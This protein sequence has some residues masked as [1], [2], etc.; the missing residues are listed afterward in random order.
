MNNSYLRILVVLIAFIS[1]FINSIQSQCYTPPAYCT[2]ISATNVGSYGMGIQNVTLNTAAIPAQINNTTS[3]G[4]GSPIYFDYTSQILTAA[5]GAVV[6]YSIRGGN[7]NQTKIRL[8]IDFDNNGTFNTTPIAT[9][10]GELVLDLAN[11][12]VANTTV[13]GTFTLPTLSAGSYRIRVASDGQGNIPPPCGPSFYS[14]DYEDYTLMVASG[15]ADA[16][17]TGIL[18]PTVLN[19]SPA[20][21]PVS[22]TVRNLTNATM[23]SISA[24]YTVNGGTATTQTFTGL[25]IA[26][27]ASYT[28]TFSTGFTAPTLGNYALK[29]F[30]YNVNGT[31]TQNTPLNDTICQTIPLLCTGPLT[32][33]Y[34]ID[35][36]GG[37]T[38]TNFTSFTNAVSAL[39]ACGVSGPTNFSVAAGT[40]TDTL[41]IPNITGVSATNT[42]TFDGGN[43][44]KAT[45]ILTFPTTSAANDV[46]RFNMSRFVTV[47]NMTLRS[48]GAT[49]GWVVHFMHDSADRVNNCNIE[50]TGAATSSSSSSFIAV[51]LNNSLT[52]YNTQSN[53]CRRNI[54][55]SNSINWGWIGISSCASLNTATN[56]FL[57]NTI[58]NSYQ[59][60]VYVEGNQVVKCNY[61]N[62]VPRSTTAGTSGIYFINSNVASTHF[63]EVLGNKIDNAGQY[64][65]YATSSAGQAAASNICANNMITGFR[66]TS[67]YGGI[68]LN[69]SSRWKLYHNSINCNLI[70]TSGTTAG[71]Y[72]ANS[73]F[74]DCRNNNIGISAT[75]GT[76]MFPVWANTTGLFTFLDYNNY[77]NASSPNLLQIN[78]VNLTA[79]NY[80]TA[81]PANG[82]AN[83]YNDNPAFVSST[84]L[85]TTQPCFNGATGLGITTDYDG[86]TR[87]GT[88][89]MGADELTAVPNNDIQVMS[90][91]TP[92][93]PLVA[94]SQPVTVVIRNLGN[95]VVSSFDVNYRLNNGTVVSEPY[96]GAPI[97]PCATVVFNFATTVTIGS[98][99]S[100][101]KAYTTSPNG[102]S[103]A[104]PSNDT[105]Q[106]T[107]C[108][109]M[110]GTYTINPL[111]SGS[112]NFT[113]FTTAIAALNCGGVNGAVTFNV[114]NGTYAE[115]LFLAPIMGTSATNTIKFQSLSG[116]AA[117]C[118]ISF[119]TPSS[120]AI[121]DLNGADFI[122]FD[123]FTIRNT[124]TSTGFGVWIR[125]G[126]DFNT[127]SNC[128]IDMAASGVNGY[129]VYQTNTIDNR[130][131]INGNTINGAGYGV[132]LNANSSSYS[133]R[134][135]ISNNSINGSYYYGMY[136]Q[137]QD[138][139]II[140]GNT[141]TSSSANS[142]YYGIYAYWLQK[143]PIVVKNKIVYTSSSA[144]TGN[145]YG[146]NLLYFNVNTSNPTRGLVANNMI[147]VG[148][149]LSTAYGIFMQNSCNYSDIIHNSVNMTNTAANGSYALY[150]ASGLSYDTVRN[151]IFHN[152][153]N[154]TSMGYAAFIY[155]G[156]Q[157]FYN[158][159]DFYTRN[160]NFALYNGTSYATY[161]AWKA[162]AAGGIS[163]FEAAGV[164]RE[165]TFTSSTDLHTTLPCIA[166]LGYNYSATSPSLTKVLDDYDGQARS[167]T[168]DLGCDEFT[169]APFDVATQLMTSPT[170][171]VFAL[172]TPYTIRTV[173]RNNGSTT[174]TALDMN[175]SVNGGA[176]TSQSFTGLSLLPCDTITL[177]F[178]SPLTLTASG[179]NA[180]K[181][182]N[183]LINTSNADGNN[184]ND[185]LVVNLCTS[186]N[187]TYSINKNLPFS[188]S[189]FTSV[190]QAVN[191]LYSCGMSGPV[192]LRID[193]G[194]GPYNEQVTFNGMIPGLNRT[195][196]LRIS[197]NTTRETITFNP[198]VATLQHTIRLIT[199]KHITLDSLT[200]NNTGAS[201]G[202]GVHLVTTA[203]SNFVT[204]SNINISLAS[205][206]LS[207]SAGIAISTNTASVTTAGNNGN[208]NVFDNNTITGGYYGI[209]A[210]GTSTTVFCK[211]NDV[212]NNRLFG[213]AFYGIYWYNQDSTKINGNTI[214][215]MLS[216]N[217]NS[218]G[219]DLRYTE[220]FELKKNK[221][222]RTG[223]YGIFLSNTNFQ[224]GTGTVR[225]EISNNMIGG[226]FYNLN[227]IGLYTQTQFRNIDF[228]HNTIHVVNQGNGNAFNMNQT[229][230][231]SHTG[232][233]FRNNTF[234]ATNNSAPV[235]YFY[236]NS[237]SIPFSNFLNNNI[238]GSNSSASQALFSCSN[239][240]TNGWILANV[241][242][243]ISGLNTLSCRNLDPQ[244]INGLTDL[245]SIQSPLSNWGTN[246]GAVTS[247]IDGDTRPL[248]PSSTVDVGA[249]EYNIP[250]LN[251]GAAS[252]VTPVAPMTTGTQDVIIQI[253]NYGL[254][255]VTSANVSY[256]VGVNGSV[257]TVA[258]TGSVAT[259]ASANV[260]FTGA[261]QYNFTGS[262]DTLIAWTDAPNGGVDGFIFNDTFVNNVVCQ[263]LAGTYTLDPGLPASTNNFVN[264]S[265]LASRLN[266]CGITGPV[267]INVAAG[268]YTEQFELKQYPGVSAVNTVTIK[269]ASGIASSVNL[270]FNTATLAANNYVVYMNGADYT[271]FQN[272]TM[273]NSNTGIG[274]YIIWQLNNSRFNT[275]QNV[276]FNGANTTSTSTNYSIIYANNTN[277]A[278]LNQGDDNNIINQCTFNNGSY[279]IYYNGSYSPYYTYNTTITNNTFS[280]QSAYATYLNFHINFNFSGNT[281]TTSTAN[282]FYGLYVSNGGVQAN[283]ASQFTTISKNNINIANNGTGMY[284]NYVN[285]TNTSPIIYP[286][287]SNNFIKIGSGTGSAYALF[288]SY[289]HARYYHNT[290]NV[291]SGS[292][293]TPAVYLQYGCCHSPL[294]E[295]KF[296]IVANSGNGTNAGQC[297]F[298]DMNTASQVKIDSNVYFQGTGA[299]SFGN[300]NGALQATFANW[301]TAMGVTFD[302]A[303]LVTNPNFVSSTNLRIN[304]GTNLRPV[305]VSPFVTDDIDNLNRCGI[306]D[307]GADHHPDGLDA[308]VS[309]ITSPANGVASPGLQDVKVL[310]TN[311]GSTT[312]TS[313]NVSYNI[314]GTVQ[315]KAWTGSLATCA[316]DTIVFTGAQ[317]YNFTG[318][319]TM[320]AFSNAPNGGADP[321]ATND[322]AYSSGCVGMGG[323]YTIGGTAGPTNFT[324]FG[325]AITAMQ[326]CGI[327]SPITFQVASGT[328][329]EQLSIPVIT[330]ASTT[331]TITFDGGNGNAATRILSFA[332]GAS[333]SGLSHVLRFNNCSFV[334]FR[335][336]TIS[337]SGTSNAWTVH[338]M[339]G[340][341]N[342]LINCIVDMTGNGTTSGSTN[343][344]SI[345]I[346]GSTTS[347]TTA[348][349]I[350]SNHRVDSCTINFGYYGIYSSINNGALTNFFTNN[351]FVNTH[352]SG[353]WFDNPQTVKFNNN[354]INTR[355][356]ST[357]A[358]PIY[359]SSA[360]P[361][362]SN[363]HEVNGNTILRTGQYG[364]FFTST[365]GGISAQ[366]QCYNNFINGM[367][368]TSSTT[369]IY[370]SS[371]SNW[372]LYHNTV[373]HDINSTSG[374]NYGI[375]IQ[376]GSNNA[377]RNNIL[378]T[379]IPTAFNWTPLFISP[380]SAASAVNSNNYWNPSSSNLVNIGGVNY[381]A[382]NF[383][384]AYPSGGGLN[385]INRNPAYVSSSNIRVTDA[386][387]NGENLGVSVDIDGQTR[388]GVPDMGADE[389]TT[390]PNNDIQVMSITVPAFPLA[391]G[392]QPVTVVIRN[393]GNN[394]V[395]SFD[396]NYRLNNGTVVTQAYSG[397]P[398]NPCAS[399]SFTFSTNVTIINGSNDL[400][401][402]TTAP[403]GVADVNPA[404]DTARY[405]SCLAMSGTYTINAS[406]SGSANFTTFTAAVNNLICGGVSGPVTFNVSNGTYNEQ[407]Q[408]PPILGASA[409]NTIR[410]Q[411]ATSNAAACILTFTPSASGSFTLYLNGAD[412]I[413]FDR[414]TI[415]NGYTASTVYTTWIGG[416]ANFNTFSNCIINNPV[417][418][419]AFAVYQNGSTDNFNTWMND[420]IN[421]GGYG[422]YLQSNTST[423][424]NRNT[425]S[426][427]FLNNQTS[428]GTANGIYVYYHDST[429][430][431]GNSITTNQS[432]GAYFGI[433]TQSLSR[434]PIV[435]KNRIYG[436]NLAGAS[437]AY[438]MQ[439]NGFANSGIG[440]G[441]IAN[442]FISMGGT[443]ATNIGLQMQNNSNNTDVMHNSI[444]MTSTVLSAN[445]VPFFYSTSL[446]G[447][448]V[449]NNIFQ[450][451]GDG[452]TSCAVANI[453]TSGTSSTVFNNNNYFSRNVTTFGYCG[454]SNGTA[455]AS[456]TAFRTGGAAI[457]SF[458]TSGLNREVL[459]VSNSDLHT[460]TACI[461]NA[462]FNVLTIVPDD[463]DGDTRTTTPDIGADQFVAIAFDN[464][465]QAIVSPNLGSYALATP[466]TVSVRV[467]NNGSTT[468]TALAM[469]YSLNGGAATSQSFTGLNLLPCDM[470]TLTFTATLTLT[471]SGSNVLRVFNGLINTSN[472]DGNN[473]NDTVSLNLCTPYS[474]TLTINKNL[475]LSSSNF[476][477]VSQAVNSLYSCGMSGP[478]VLRIDAG[479]GPY[480]EQV[481]FNGMITGLTR[482]NN[483]RIS[484]NTTRET[485]TFNPTVSNLQHT[486]R[487]I[488]VKHITLDSLT[489]NNTGANFGV[490]VHLV[491][492]AD[493]NFVTNSNINISLASTS[494][495]NSAGIAIS[496]NTSSPT[497]TGNSG[498]G[499]K[500]MN[501]TIT[502]GYYGI[503]TVGTNTTTFCRNNDIINNTITGQAYYGVYSQF[504]DSTKINQNT[505]RNLLVTNTIGIGI[506]CQYIERFEIN[507]N[508][509]NYVGQSGFDLSFMNFQNGT[510]TDRSSIVN[511]MIGGF[512]YNNSATGINLQ[513]RAR[514]IDINHN[515][516]S[517]G[518]NT[519]GGAF[520][521][522]YSSSGTYGGLVF[523][524]NSLVSYN[525][526]SSVGNFYWNN[527][528]LTPAVPFTAFEN[529]NIFNA[530]PSATGSTTISSFGQNGF[531]GTSWIG[532]SINGLNTSSSISVNPFYLN[533]L[534][535]LHTLNTA[536]SNKGT[537]VANVNIDI[538]GQARPLSP[539]VIVDIGADEYNVPADN[540]GVT[541]VISPSAPL[542]PGLQ[543][544]VVQIR[545]YGSTTLT[546]A[547]VRYKVG[548]NGTTRSIAWTGSVATNATTN[549]TFT[550]ANQHNFTGSFDTIIAWTDAPNG[551]PDG[552]TAND[553]AVSIICSPLSGTYT[554]DTTLVSG[555]GNFNSWASALAS[556]MNCGVS[557]P[558]TINVTQPGT[559]AGAIDIM[560]I[561]GSSS[562][563]TV[564]FNGV[565][566]VN[567]ILVATT[568]S[569]APAVLRF[570]N[571]N[572]VT[573]RNFT[574]RTLGANDGWCAHFFNGL[575]NRVT[576]C[577]LDI[578][579]A[580]TASASSNLIPVV[581]N[582]NYTNSGTASTT[583]NNHSV[584]SS[585]LNAGYYS[586]YTSN[587][588][589]TNTYRFLNNTMNNAYQ[590]GAYFN[591]SHAIK[592]NNNIVNMRGI[593]GGTYGLYIINNNPS[594]PNFHEINGNK[595]TNIGQYG[596]YFATSSNSGSTMGQVFNNM[597]SGFKSTSTNVGIYNSSSSRWNIWHNSINLDFASTSGTN[598]CIYLQNGGTIDLR[599]NILSVTSPTIVNATPL[600]ISPSSAASALN[601][602]LYYN[603]SSANLIGGAINSTTSN[604]KL[605]FPSG[606]GLGSVNADPRFVNNA[607]DL[608]TLNGCYT[609]ANLGVTVDIDNQTRGTAP[610]IGAD[611]TGPVVNND[612]GIVS[613]N[614]PAFPLVAG[615]TNVNVTLRNFGANTVSSVTVSYRVNGGTLTSQTL[616][617]LSL[618]PCDTLNFT[619]S[620]PFV[621]TGS[622][623]LSVFTSN[624][625]GVTDVYLNND[626][627]NLSLCVAMSGS[628]SI[629][630][631]GDFT[632]FTQAVS[633]LNCAGVNG[634]VIFNVLSNTFAEQ[635][636]IGVIQGASASNTITFDGGV[637]NAA[638]R[639]LT[640]A[641]SAANP[642]TFRLNGSQFV[643]IINLTI[644]S[645]DGVNGW[646]VSI[647][648]AKNCIVS[649][650]NIEVAGAGA[651]ATGSNLA[652]VVLN[653]STTSM[654]TGSSAI[655]NVYIDSNRIRGGFHG[656]YVNGNL[657]NTNYAYTRD[658]IIDSAYQNGIF[659]NNM[660]HKCNN[661][662]II[663]RV[664]GGP[665]NSAGIS[666]PSNYTQTPD[667]STYNYNQI[668]NAR[669]YGIFIS[670][671]FY[672]N[673]GIN[674]QVNNNVIGQFL[675]TGVTYGIFSGFST[676]NEYYH[677]TININ[678]AATGAS[679]AMQ[680]N[681]SSSIF[682]RNNIFAITNA[683][684]ASTS[685]PIQFTNSGS[686]T[687]SNNCYY[688]A[689]STNIIQTTSG[690]FTT[691]AITTAFPSG[692]GAGSITTDPQFPAAG[693]LRLGAAV[694]GAT[695]N[696]TVSIAS[697]PYDMDNNPRNPPLG[698]TTPDMGAYDKTTSNVGVS[699]VIS[700]TAV[701]AGNTHSI[702][703]RIRNYGTDAV[704]N[705]PVNYSLNGGTAVTETYVP[706]L[707][708]NDS[709]S[710][711]FATTATFAGCNSIR[712]YTSL[713]GESFPANDTASRNI[714]ANI[715]GVYTIN[716][717]GAGA[718][719]FT[720]FANAIAFLNCGMVTGPVTFQ[721]AAATYNEQVVIPSTIVG[722]TATNTITFDGG[723]GNAATRILTFAT[724]AS[725]SGLS[726]VLRF[727][728]CSFITFRNMTIRSSGI[729][730]AWTVH[731]MNGTNNRLNS[732]I[733]DMT[734][735]GTTST[736]TNFTSVV[737]N[738][739]T[740]SR[741]TNSTAANNHR[742]DSC[743]IN[744]GY[745]GIFTA[746]NNGALTNFF[747]NN[748]FANTYFSGG[749]FQ[750]AQTV[751]FNNNTINTRSTMTT[752]QPIYFTSANPSGLNFHEVNGNTIVRT[753]QYGIFF[754]S[755]QGGPSTQGQ[756]YNNFI[757]GMTSTS[758]TTG[759]Y[760]SSASNWNLYH[761]TVNHDINSTTGSSFGIQILNGSNNDVRNNILSTTI[762]TTVSWTPFLINPSSAVSAVNSNNYWNPSSS[763][764]VTIGGVN[765]TAA[766]FN[767][768]YP[769]GGGLNSINKNPFYVSASN[770]HVTS[771]CNNGENLGVLVDIDG[772]TRAGIP[773]MGA[774]EVTTVFTVS[775]T[776]TPVF[777]TTGG[778]VDTIVVTSGDTVV[779]SGTGANSYSWSGPQLITNAVSFVATSAGEYT[780]TGTTSGCTNTKKVYVKL[781][782]ALVTATTAQN[783]VKL[784]RRGVI[785]S[786][787]YY[788]DGVNYYFAIDTS[789]ITSGSLTGD[790]VIISVQTTIDSSKS[791]NGRNQEHAMYLMPRFWN[792][793]GSFTGTVKVRFPY[794]PSDTA[795]LVSLRDSA[796][797]RL[798]N[799][800]NIN[801]RAVKTPY[802]EWFKTVGRPYNASYISGM[803]GNKFPSTKAKPTV[804]YGVT[805]GGVH[806][807]ELGGITSFS[808]GSAGVGFGPGGGGGGVSLPATWAG[809]DVQTLESGNELT[810]KTA[811]EKNTDY[812][813]V[814]YSYDA[815]DFQVASHKIQAAGN[816]ASLSYYNFNHSDFNSF[817]Y[818]R[819]KQVDLDGQFDYS[820]IKL[821][822]RAKGKEFQV[823]VYPT[824]ILENGRITIEA[825]NI[826]KSQISLSIM[827]VSGKVIYTNSY[828]PSND[829]L[830]E[831]IE[832]YLLSSGV[833]F[834]EIS[835]GQGRDVVKVLR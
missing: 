360:N 25:S 376:N 37:F 562:V 282:N 219:M 371:A 386:C 608:H 63:H 325:A 134:N 661:N 748:N 423:Y 124:F 496:S 766:N 493:S 415:T 145:F 332:T 822:K 598:N 220:R 654:G 328:Y 782:S 216:S 171:S 329:T 94:G 713:A 818:Y 427:C 92:V 487:L 317:Q 55:D 306:T 736:S 90:I 356:S 777:S 745:Y 310:L 234:T 626:T 806:Y 41:Y 24:G 403:N 694:A 96:A 602:N 631:S 35:P 763:N 81:S 704:S 319:F 373:N 465:S 11:M 97:S 671:S 545:N 169:T 75:S 281:I 42:I 829:S 295:F 121:I 18:Q 514:N 663:M 490:G 140:S 269:S 29:Y 572:F 600:F 336:M 609:G 714:G 408:I 773:D 9:A 639:I 132:F 794:L 577:I 814:E 302:A 616:T 324:T 437:T 161:A 247:D 277:A 796:W 722:V 459:F 354:A 291:T 664:L 776:S 569:A 759:I 208:N 84:N 811:S 813:E 278:Q 285:G 393:L 381:T 377:V 46:V 657:V 307:V 717:S 795:L 718:T 50:F 579:G 723:S 604:Y 233:D 466:Y 227:P 476:T 424:S 676:N 387:N 734:G 513:S 1:G 802:L 272:M 159:N 726:H 184:I 127:I 363:F 370:L 435:T 357:T 554:I 214:D 405:T 40:Y 384:V 411:S 12:T 273:T 192:V 560:G 760:L 761:N 751:K 128:I 691:A 257:K 474:G 571:C 241:S 656:I 151:N 606:G 7:S 823:S 641:A 460:S 304:S 441:L 260:T 568:S 497:G 152:I 266:N 289:S 56:Y 323:V 314:N 754:T 454:S 489:I 746:I 517:M 592:F 472:A 481:T 188:S 396:V 57:S 551:Q 610:D 225:S 561:N 237:G 528:G 556:L 697:L 783:G 102:S 117:N 236:Y 728:N 688:N 753:G 648:D 679:R 516:I 407:I 662:R 832:L 779:L 321:N 614:S 767:V 709:V 488:T 788:G 637:G 338:F 364:I 133:N 504:Q 645:T 353:G 666:I 244:F 436:I 533:S 784:T 613:L 91:T 542:T 256:K 417:N 308:G 311:I 439:H 249:D 366:G 64:G 812:F 215:N 157:M 770:I 39:R 599:N 781:G 52:S 95:N 828:N 620:T 686:T 68:F 287:V 99:T 177:T 211:R 165:V 529:N 342:R 374:P 409:T 71:I 510:G 348:S 800:T 194:S 494:F 807:V 725:G 164:S 762:P 172:A 596:I 395:S 355:T 830:R 653:G 60:G 521:I 205:A 440:R 775:Y 372:N 594:S 290:F 238:W 798:K 202:V 742:V 142:S 680:I 54:V 21:N 808:G 203:D 135:V 507:R 34:T 518:N 242:S 668:Y 575:N 731:F 448:T 191:S 143:G 189:N 67:G 318:S 805:G 647:V 232:L 104:V 432:S 349:T 478:V 708:G 593:N 186:Y 820:E 747:T 17:V 345:V 443:A 428:T 217:V 418:P 263:S 711:T 699:A 739:S 492:A 120:Q 114:S 483:L 115:Q 698:T 793:M 457:A 337:S 421:N 271:R 623:N 690:T 368:S 732:C 224:N 62:I 555:S 3:P 383:N 705:I 786:F 198:T 392:S 659:S 816:S 293:T 692:G 716:P 791:S 509:V 557:G 477:S 315:T 31:T 643:N 274:S 103:D 390:A 799:V 447:N 702:T 93:F 537:N 136:F 388:A 254:T 733:V 591:S 108:N 455:T 175:Y 632:T 30:L 173:V 511:N 416:S 530:N 51:V 294:Q 651:T 486:I 502:G 402:F 672:S 391:G 817:V 122:T 618:S 264:F 367:N 565:N 326:A 768:A 827:D 642:H 196:N 229:S 404:N 47:R 473:T 444:N 549:V 559:Y 53:I 512:F 199:V 413:T 397:S 696:S 525:S 825:K 469:N 588:T 320:K 343:F 400:R 765:Y 193:A 58:S 634:P 721:V 833:Y 429:L 463:I 546:S 744:F 333:S 453:G 259:N 503:S 38:A 190:S 758:S 419:N 665:S 578:G 605:A 221:I 200:I 570:N 527:S 298:S 297:I 231:T 615:S 255:T 638:S 531:S 335:N 176:V 23:T 125:N 526:L 158:N 685:I 677:N 540:S 369:G 144:S 26:S 752:A 611:E 519:S 462:G 385:S 740:T 350:A 535:D 500:I 245:H 183:G 801:T 735:N 787:I 69:S 573:F 821:A 382:S 378:S 170:G 442:N 785:G 498:N 650:C 461:K 422:I 586:V 235:G 612:M 265:S 550:G 789:G 628:Y 331:N 506:W 412:F 548:V 22:F 101:F 580:G 658:N 313:A 495:S 803:V 584:D 810:W 467:R 322:T 674:Q 629:G 701:T 401:V 130:N 470:T 150:M 585:T 583:G 243:C 835:N 624:P 239:Y 636:S 248:S 116:V 280:Q 617:G 146:M 149:T 4:S 426:N 687:V 123:K 167:T 737:I 633:Q 113:S 406:G 359:F 312:L 660:T 28:V 710:Y 644:R 590:Y 148:G 482:V 458:E 119:S 182:F 77:F 201:F 316:F 110:N 646:P 340:V 180:L 607:T 330:G 252:V 430:I 251:T 6:N 45:R 61:N 681:N 207:N 558:V 587:S 399:A 13:S 456:F 379:T 630:P 552:F 420:T 764:L 640:F 564:T 834:I 105:A 88:P 831:E 515:S 59:Y 797:S 451:S 305:P 346:N 707:N 538:D 738:G 155:S 351:N 712:C 756:C 76:S 471:A 693:N 185:T 667:F 524:N 141:I 715:A 15:T 480:N 187:G 729:S 678:N 344:A 49:Q 684:A 508:N 824:K 16:L 619:F 20:I 380:S 778:G 118:I 589:G 505:I 491:T 129:G 750:N 689:A 147:Q 724:G 576:N 499:N 250:N 749:W 450:A 195:N 468:I 268:T 475:P 774:D 581:M 10:G 563:N 352:Y 445:V 300:Y 727:N 446:S 32:G 43:G 66:N 154:G 601:N 44:N 107:L 769:S 83:S 222:N 361:S 741:T 425:I 449:R 174:I 522:S 534:N 582:G 655:H 230:A 410:F 206:S 270:Q 398:L 670:G 178:T 809:F 815:K 700:L 138:S 595:F 137:Y 682:V 539:D 33:S 160:S 652:A 166:D 27:G 279:G 669:Q 262:F 288:S 625:N 223:Q 253:K 523:R 743:T 819:I 603:A 213:Q 334:T 703:V 730:E 327:G 228:W 566:S 627:T 261:N 574:I 780:V 218:F 414:I 70:A 434:R 153:G 433:Q 48:T 14:A 112:T 547:N 226:T 276:V 139:V 675:G 179:S 567:R 210:M 275:F 706:T 85:H 78:S 89:D 284:L 296:N 156:T 109:A 541:A 309:A 792:A 212:T 389:V 649:N 544:V 484:G 197:G 375:Q 536:L 126:A 106:W 622:T 365:Q 301:K 804:T 204:N 283:S 757:N 74:T 358:Q 720:T 240:N 464:V 98:G 8:F 299:G 520:S 452:M 621:V 347:R 258:W 673:A 80:K 79:S 438:G 543:N 163:G 168:P 394:V 683:S 431:T 479:S 719:N 72:N 790:T 341:N 86:E 111:G 485:I 362:G 246:I 73:S 695:F 303:S 100:N 286:L 82:G 826:D 209:S 771:V 87:A 553:T 131:T 292:T 597:I 755:T 5:S 36:A 162:A 181:I 19:A 2:S 65:V 267:T 772:Q 339:N 501:N 532:A 635:V